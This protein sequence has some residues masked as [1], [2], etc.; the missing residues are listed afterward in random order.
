MDK[1]VTVANGKYTFIERDYQVDIL[2]NFEPWIS[3]ISGANA[4]V[5]LMDRVRELEVQSAR[6]PEL[7]AEI[8]RIH[9]DRVRLADKLAEVKAVVTRPKPELLSSSTEPQR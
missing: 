3:R 1:R 6:V 5:A 2:R 7:E 9:A 4:I 8:T